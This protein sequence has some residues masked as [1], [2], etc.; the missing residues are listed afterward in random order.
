MDDMQ[1]LVLYCFGLKTQ[2]ANTTTKQYCYP[3]SVCWPCHI[4]HQPMALIILI[5]Y[6][7]WAKAYLK[8]KQHPQSQIFKCNKQKHLQTVLI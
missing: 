6:T 7:F 1:V 5:A 2:V 4:G 3:I 8:K